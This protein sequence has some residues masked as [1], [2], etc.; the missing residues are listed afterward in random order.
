MMAAL[1]RLTVVVVLSEHT[2]A[3][4]ET[5]VYMLRSTLVKKPQQLKKETKN[6][7]NIILLI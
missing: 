1:P 3:S 6:Y 2:Q 5:R 7:Y 4:T